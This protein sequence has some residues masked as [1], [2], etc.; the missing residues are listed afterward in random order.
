MRREGV[1]IASILRMTRSTMAVLALCDE[2][3]P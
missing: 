3:E 2:R 1:V